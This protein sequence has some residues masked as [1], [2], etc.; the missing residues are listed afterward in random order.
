[1]IYTM[2]KLNIYFTAGAA[3][4]MGATSCKKIDELK[5]Y[6]EVVVTT[7]FTSVKDASAWDVGFYAKFRS[8]QYGEYML[9]TDAQSDELNATLDYGNNYGSVH[10]WGTNLLSSD[11]Y[12]GDIWNNE[13]N[14]IA[15]VNVALAGFPGIKPANA[16]E[17]AQLN[18]YTADGLLARAYMY[19]VLIQRWGKAYNASTA[20]SDPGV[21]LLTKYNRDEM[22]PRA[23]VQA[24]YTQILA[25]ITQAKT[26]LADVPGVQGASTFTLDA[27]IA[28]EARVRLEMKDYAGAYTA[29][30]SLISGGKYPL[31]TTVA[32]LQNFWYNDGTQE[33][34]YQSYV[35]QT[36][37]P[38][39]NSI[40]IAYNSSIKAN[41]PLFIPTQTM[42]NLFDDNDIRKS[43]FLIKTTATISAVQY[44][45]YLVNK[46][47]G[48]PTLF[49][50]TNSNY[51]NAPKTF[52]IG[53]IYCIAAEAAS[54]G[55]NDAN[56]LT[57]INA[58]RVARG[59][60]AFT[61]ISG[62][63]LQTA[64][65]QERTRELAFEG[66]RLDDLKRWHLGFNGRL[67]QNVNAIQA[68][69]TYEQLNISAD[70]PKFVWGIPSQDITVNPN[71]TQ[72]P[73]W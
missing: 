48:N 14:G 73:G 17:T 10:R 57:A 60:A 50:G 69:A 12:L 53:E 36:Q 33:S 20:T 28:L 32:G 9:A 27:A 44:N 43:T 46:Y 41:D 65:Q 47:P 34:I 22:P 39:T 51:Q 5:P 1:M 70:D 54:Y 52:T 42:V 25:D 61:G 62:T 40:Y 3:L 72:N 63:A 2:K 67:P 23:S 49:T 68:G 38:N 29:A 58:L 26:L 56:A 37:T 8:L 35:S 24:V 4:L 7:S 45:L 13:Y 21:P 66:F 15:D 59:V 30:Q 64:I 19:N 31:L 71:L 55:G 6:D 11:G 16:A 18:H